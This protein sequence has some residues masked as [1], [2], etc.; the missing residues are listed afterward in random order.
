MGGDV[1]AQWTKSSR[2]TAVA[3]VGG[4]EIRDANPRFHQ[5]DGGGEA[6]RWLNGPH[7]KVRYGTLSELVRAEAAT[8]AP[9]P[10][11]SRFERA[12]QV[13]EVRLERLAPGEAVAIVHDVTGDLR[14]QRELQRDREALLHEERMHAMGVLASGVAHDLNHVL[15]VIALRVATLRAD[16]ALQG[17]RR[18]LEALG[19]VVSDAARIVARLQDLARKRRDRPSDRRGPQLPLVTA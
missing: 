19:R 8:L 13:I 9:V 15:N 14:R 7:A 4:G 11:L 2:S 16:P 12:R 17:A 6:W 1:L 3:L 5:L 18:T 10:Y